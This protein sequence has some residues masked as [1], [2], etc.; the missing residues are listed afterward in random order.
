M[1]PTVTG[2]AI[3][4]AGAVIGAAGAYLGNIWNTSKTIE[5]DREHRVWERR[6]DTYLQALTAVEYLEV[7]RGTAPGWNGEMLSVFLRTHDEPDWQMLDARMSAFASNAVWEAME[8]VSKAYRRLPSLERKPGPPGLEKVSAEAA[9]GASA[10]TTHMAALNLVDL[11]RNELQSIRRRLTRTQRR[12]SRS[13]RRRLEASM[14][15]AE[16]EADAERRSD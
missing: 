16:A 1:D 8:G 5:H 4:L 11:I 6:A 14:R 7:T 9:I 3:G 2:A 13:R 15:F 10:L 12:S